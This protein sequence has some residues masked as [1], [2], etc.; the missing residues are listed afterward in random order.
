MYSVVTHTPTRRLAL[1]LFVAGKL[2]LHTP[3]RLNSPD[4]VRP[5][6]VS[7]AV[8]ARRVRRVGTRN[9]RQRGERAVRERERVVGEWPNAT[10]VLL[11]DRARVLD[12]DAHRE[13]RAGK[14]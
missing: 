11:N 1:P 12:V 8:Y 3:F 14:H 6:D 9:L 5:H 7:P 4:D 10:S 2:P 13:R